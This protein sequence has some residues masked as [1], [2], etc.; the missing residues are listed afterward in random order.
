MGLLFS[1]RSDRYGIL[2]QSHIIT[3]EVWLQRTLEKLLVKGHCGD[4]RRKESL[5]EKTA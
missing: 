4:V 1:S 2:T 3:R 5:E